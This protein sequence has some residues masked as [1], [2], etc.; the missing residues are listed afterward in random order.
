MTT[1]DVLTLRG[2]CKRFGDREVLRGLDLSVPAGSIFGFVG[3]N[4]AGKTTTMKAILGLLRIDCGE[5]LVS[6]E[7]VCYGETPTNRH[8]GYL[9]DVPEFYGFMSPREYLSLCGE[10]MGMAKREI[11]ARSDALLSL[12]GLADDGHRIGGFSRGMKQ[13]LGIAQ[14]LLAR[15]KLLICDEPTSALDPVGRREILDLLA[16]VRRETTVLFSTHILTDVER[17]ATDLAF[18]DGGS[19]VL[20][21]TVDQI[22]RAHSL[23]EF[24]VETLEPC[25]AERLLSAFDGVRPIDA[26]T[27][28]FAGD[29]ARMLSVLGFLA[30]E[31]LPVRRVEC[32]EPSLETLFMEVVKK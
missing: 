26:T 4:G 19:I 27:L 8:I 29:E 2:V 16:S 28:A 31:Q 1:C 9:P 21:G 7:R 18:L 23:K 13:R 3:K 15:P 5:I 20:S 17:I 11:A 22:K 24:V 12:V 32:A 25:V 14:A 30:K 10:S 6:G